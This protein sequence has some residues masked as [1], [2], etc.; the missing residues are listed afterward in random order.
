MKKKKKQKKNIVSQP[1]CL[2]FKRQ[3]SCAI[4]INLGKYASHGLL[5]H[6]SNKNPMQASNFHKH[7]QKEKKKKKEKKGEKKKKK[8]KIGWPYLYQFS[9]HMK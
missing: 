7:H 3:L 5:A 2:V 4:T 6:E 9:Y 1:K 8:K